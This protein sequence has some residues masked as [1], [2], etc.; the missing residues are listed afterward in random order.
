MKLHLILL[1]LFIT[2]NLYGQKADYEADV[3]L[4]RV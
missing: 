3:F 2:L 1:S 4:L